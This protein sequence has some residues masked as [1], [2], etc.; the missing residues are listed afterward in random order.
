MW[1]QQC[2]A[3]AQYKDQCGL[4]E[5]TDYLGMLD[6]SI[7]INFRVSGIQRL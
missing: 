3:C 7:K 2:L 5:L 6:M 1:N 4:K